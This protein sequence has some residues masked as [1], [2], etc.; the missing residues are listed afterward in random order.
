MTDWLLYLISFAAGM[1]LGIVFFGGLW[2]TVKRAISSKRPAFWFIASL[3][4]RSALVMGGFYL[5]AGQHWQ[6][7]LVSLCGFVVSRIV[8]LYLTKKHLENE[9]PVKGGDQDESDLG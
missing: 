5:A 2:L 7:L 8:I 6:R 9:T 3:L 4:V 1:A